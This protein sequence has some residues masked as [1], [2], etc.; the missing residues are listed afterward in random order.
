MII[1]IFIESS[2]D[3]DDVEHDGM[4]YTPTFYSHM[5]TFYSHTYID[6]YTPIFIDIRIFLF[7]S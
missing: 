4:R 5:P 2:W 3:C 6:S 7:K 1:Y